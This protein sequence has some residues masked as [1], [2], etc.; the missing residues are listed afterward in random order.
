MNK[1]HEENPLT[2]DNLEEDFDLNEIK[3]DS[4]YEGSGIKI[5]AT[6]IPI[7]KPRKQ[8]WIC[9]H[10]DETKRITVAVI[11]YGDQKDIYIAGKKVIDDLVGEHVL[12]TL[13]LSVTKQGDYFFLPIKL[14]DAGGFIDSWNESLAEIVDRYKGQW[15]RILPN[16]GMGRYDVVIS[17]NAAAPI[18]TDEPFESLLKKALKDR[19][20]NSLDHFVVKSLKGLA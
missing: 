17:N 9:T 6:K 14:P 11:E 13:V 3:M 18:W 16:Q 15:I 4:S 20:I 7:Q 5:V 8:T 2:Q 10:P 19:I 12:K 1:L